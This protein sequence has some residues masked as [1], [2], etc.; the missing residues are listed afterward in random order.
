M[1]VYHLVAIL[2]MSL[3]HAAPSQVVIVR[4]GEKLPLPN[5]GPYTKS[6]N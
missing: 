2:S 6:P 1:N 4:H 5:P 3:L